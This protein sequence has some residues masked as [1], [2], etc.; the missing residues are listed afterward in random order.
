MLKIH[1]LTLGLYQVNCYIVYNEDSNR[2]V[3]IDPGYEPEKIAAFLK[4]NSLQSDAILLTHGHFD[5]V[6]GVKALAGSCKVYLHE[7]E[8]TMPEALTAGPLYATNNYPARF[9]IA[10]MDFTVLHAPG[11]TPGSV[12]LICEDAMF[13]GDTL[14]QECCG[15]TDLETGSL[16]DILRSLKRLAQLEG[17]YRVFPGHEGF[18]SLEYERQYNPYIRE[19]MRR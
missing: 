6:G 3:V 1:T 5:H 11:H 9:S 18:S 12:C 19:A 17:N 15:R 8:R 10:G 14:F 2:C 4:K 7:L 16:E 13:S